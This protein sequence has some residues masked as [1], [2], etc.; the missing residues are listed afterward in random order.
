MV[1]GTTGKGT[2]FVYGIEL[3]MPPEEEA[4]ETETTPAPPAEETPRTEDEYA[5]D[6]ETEEETAEYPEGN[7]PAEEEYDEYVPEWEEGA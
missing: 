4:E 2:S 7:N 3:K 1:I 5:P 6:E